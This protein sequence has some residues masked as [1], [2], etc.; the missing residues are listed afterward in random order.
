MDRQVAIDQ[1]TFEFQLQHNI[2]SCPRVIHRAR[3]GQYSGSV[4]RSQALDAT[5]TFNY[6]CN[7]SNAMDT[8]DKNQCT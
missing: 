4:S 8:S 1:V 5:G 6:D 3:R 7:S 2:F